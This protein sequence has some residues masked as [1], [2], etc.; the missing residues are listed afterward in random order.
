VKEKSSPGESLKKCLFSY[1]F[2]VFV[3]GSFLLI[4]RRKIEKELCNLHE[5]IR[6]IEEAIQSTG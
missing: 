2:S 6:R 5:A 1:F 4:R 3:D